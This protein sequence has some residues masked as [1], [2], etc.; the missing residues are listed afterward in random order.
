MASSSQ[1]AEEVLKSEQNA[2]P[3]P[4]NCSLPPLDLSKIEVRMNS[5][6]GLANGWKL[7]P[8]QVKA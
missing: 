1:S 2:K 5:L 3:W 6:E 8:D 4:K 7:F